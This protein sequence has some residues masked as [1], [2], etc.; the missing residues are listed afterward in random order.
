MSEAQIGTAVAFELSWVSRLHR[1]VHRLALDLTSA[2]ED[3]RV[4]LLVRFSEEIEEPPDAWSR[5]V[6]SRILL[7][8]CDRSLKKLHE[9][10]SLTPC[11]CYAIAWSHL[12]AL[13][14]WHERDV[15]DAFQKCVAAIADNFD[16][17]HRPTDPTLIARA[18]RSK[19]AQK[20][21][22]SDFLHEVSGRRSARHLRR[23]FRDQF[24]IGPATYV[25]LVRT[26]RA[27][28]LL[29]TQMKIEAIAWEVGY[30][31][32]KELYLALNRWVGLTPKRIKALPR[33][34]RDALEWQLH[35]WC[36]QGVQSSGTG[37]RSQPS[38]INQ[39]L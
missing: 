22:L 10:T 29:A 34:R 39:S 36:N 9:V 24:G 19:P 16:R 25:Q 7:F 31:G 33:E 5:A 3:E 37:K 35:V 12:D 18:I 13:S 11:N 21:R 14:G 4:R 8:V 20:N 2:D 32:K 30:R 1:K 6:L 17:A 26:R 28:Q 23:E 38:V 15:R 27:V